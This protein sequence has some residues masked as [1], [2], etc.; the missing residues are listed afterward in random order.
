M[1]IASLIRL[2]KIVAL[3]GFLLPWFA[4]SCSDKKLIEPRGYE[5]ALGIEIK[6]HEDFTSQARAPEADGLQLIPVKAEAPGSGDNTITGPSGQPRGWTP[7]PIV[8]ATAAGAFL[9]AA[10]S[11]GVGFF[12]RGQSFAAVSAGC[13][14]AAAGLAYATVAAIE[15][16][17]RRQISEGTQGADNP[18]A[19][20]A[21]SLFRVSYEPGVWVTVCAAAGAGLL[22]T[23][24]LLLNAQAGQAGRAGGPSG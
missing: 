19:G 17:L 16:E 15:S 10:I 22:A 8:Q 3:L 4:V 21:G 7:P 14:F 2:L 6:A 23:Y 5:I 18:F 13:G 20:L 24:L 12:L 9:L 11:F 1:V